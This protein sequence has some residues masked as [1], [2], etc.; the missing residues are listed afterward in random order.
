MKNSR[1]FNKLNKFPFLLQKFI[2]LCGV[3][4]E[5]LNELRYIPIKYRIYVFYTIFSR[6]VKL[7]SDSRKRRR[8]G[9]VLLILEHIT[10]DVTIFELMHVMRIFNTLHP[11][12][13]I[14]RNHYENPPSSI[15]ATMKTLPGRK[16]LNIQI[17]TN[18]L[19]ENEIDFQ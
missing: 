14:S 9:N 11:P 19:E 6:M 5:M 3:I 1:Q 13:S 15:P 7:C 17:L 12:F 8:N 4:I 16:I 18:I 10:F 2:P